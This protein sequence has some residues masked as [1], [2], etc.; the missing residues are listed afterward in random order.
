M[1]NT[2]KH[3]LRAD[4]IDALMS[5]WNGETQRAMAQKL[6]LGGSWY[7][8]LGL[9][10]AGNTEGVLS[11]EAENELRHALGL[12][13]IGTAEVPICPHHGCAHTVDN[14]G[15]KTVVQ[16]VAL[17]PDEAIKP[18]R[19]VKT[20]GRWADYSPS[21]LAQALRNRKEYK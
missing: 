3:V 13:Y 12:S 21:A 5:C 15:G 18:K 19:R 9:I 16:V 4:T 14:C 6:N 20:P 7:T 1:V 17:A 2:R 10:K 11:Q 8:R